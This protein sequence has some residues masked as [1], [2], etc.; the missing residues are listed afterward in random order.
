MKQSAKGG[1]AG[2]HRRK[3][4]ITSWERSRLGEERGKGRGEHPTLDKKEVDAF[5]TGQ[6][7]K[8]AVLEKEEKESTAA[9]LEER[10]AQNRRVGELL[11]KGG[12]PSFLTGREGT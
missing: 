7:G 9:S 3:M 2:F 4:D 11:V 12:K 10:V 6:R 8:G 5:A 1:E